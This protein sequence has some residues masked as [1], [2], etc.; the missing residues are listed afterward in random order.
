[1]IV[2][3]RGEPPMPYRFA[4]KKQALAKSMLAVY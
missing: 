2:S 3:Q 1:M 4:A